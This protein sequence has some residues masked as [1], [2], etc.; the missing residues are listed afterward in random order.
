M[1]NELT[2]I[3]IKKKQPIREGG[4]C[5]HVTVVKMKRYDIMQPDAFAIETVNNDSGTSSY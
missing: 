1:K 2:L 3:H 5:G 4:R